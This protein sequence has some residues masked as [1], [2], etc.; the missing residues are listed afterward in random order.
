[1]RSQVRFVMD[2]ADEA[3]FIRAI[4]DEPGTVLVDGPT[5]ATSNQPLPGPCDN[6]VLSGQ[7]P[8][9]ASPLRYRLSTS[10]D[11]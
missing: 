2:P 8:P 9:T 3:E 1:M 10:L 6:A 7:S 4:V 5:W 11:R